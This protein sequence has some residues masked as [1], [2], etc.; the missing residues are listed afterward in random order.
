MNEFYKVKDYLYRLD[1]D[2]EVDEQNYNLS[3]NLY[4]DLAI[5]INGEELLI[6]V[7]KEIRPQ[8]LSQLNFFDKRPL[9]IVADYITPKAKI[10]LKERGFNYLD[11]FGN[12]YLKLT[13]MKIY[14]EKSNARPVNIRNYQSFSRKD[15]IVIYYLL[16]DPNRVNQ[17]YRDIALKTNTSLGSVSNTFKTLKNKGFIVHWTKNEKYQLIKREELLSDWITVL[18]EKVL[19][20]YKIGNF[21]FGESTEYPVP[22]GEPYFKFG[23]ETGAAML[24]HHLN[25]VTPS[26]FTRFTRQEL[27]RRFRLIP[28]DDGTIQIFQMF[29]PYDPNETPL[30]DIKGQEA[31]RAVHPLLIYAQ[32]I[33]SNDSRNIEVAELIYNEY[34]TGLI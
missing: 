30:K 4:N 22:E 3:N 16:Q 10:M 8:H 25:P 5:L 21:E 26:L 7:K 15:G 9:L 34:I 24:T 13:D 29:W 23:G 20:Y 27:I 11:S 12:G 33:Y 19:P 14:I 31:E 28:R 6:E 1:S 32:L 2:L 18:N 17:T